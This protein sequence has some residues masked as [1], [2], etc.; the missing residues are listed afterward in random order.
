V[1]S[2]GARASL[3]LLW[4]SVKMEGVQACALG[5]DILSPPLPTSLWGPAKMYR[6]HSD[7]GKGGDSICS[8]PGSP[9]SII[10]Q[11]FQPPIK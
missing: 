1:R 5:I 10:N 9:T 2:R 4:G 8:F 6:A 7:V 11:A 3:R